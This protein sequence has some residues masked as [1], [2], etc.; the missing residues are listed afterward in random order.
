MADRPILFSAPMIRALRDGRKTQT[1]R[2]VAAQVEE[3]LPS[4]MQEDLELQGRLMGEEGRWIVLKK[5]LRFEES[6]RLWVREAFTVNGWATDVATIFYRANE[7]ASYSEMCA[8]F[9]VTG[10][11]IISPTPGK[12]RP[13]I[14][15]PRWASRLTLIVEGVKVERLQD[16][17]EADA[18]AEGCVIGKISGH[19]FNDIAALRLGGPEWKNARDWYAD[20]WEEINGP[21]SWE[22]NPWVVALS[23]RTIKANID[24]PEAKA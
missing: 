8:Q 20:L 5:P 24:S 10:R 18:K 21:E 14:H 3:S 16:I 12:W 2:V 11:K 6:D 1:R 13:G 7:R 23:F 9:P 22:A 15:L 17:S 4:E 19:A